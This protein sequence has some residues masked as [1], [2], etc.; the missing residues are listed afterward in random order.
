MLFSTVAALSATTFHVSVAGLGGEPDY[1]VRFT[2]LANEAHKLIASTPDAKSF[3]LT[4]AGA[5]KAKLRQT[6]AQIAAEAKPDD[7]VVLLLIGHGTFDGT[8]YKINLPG[9]DLSA[10]ELDAELD[11]IPVQKQLVVNTTSASGASISTLQKVNRVIVAST[12]SGSEKNAPVFARYW[13]EALRD[14]GADADKNEGVSALEAYRYADQKTVQY[15]ERNKRL[16]TEH[17]LL[18]DTGKGD[19]VRAPTNDNGQGQVAGRLTLL[20]LGSMQKAAQDPAKQ[21]LIRRKEDVEQRI[22]QLKYNKAALPAAEYSKQL[23]A[24]LLEL[25]KVQAEL[26][27]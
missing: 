25:A 10:V 1:D 21:E 7:T 6:L 9:P 26:D 20:R 18:E 27:K 14:P 11:R 19:G 15:Y 16:A 5:T 23:R 4:G 13:V 12:K 22:D 17:A 8:D 24:L 3:V 2:G